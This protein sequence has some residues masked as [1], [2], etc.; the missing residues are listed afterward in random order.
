MHSVLGGGKTL[1]MMGTKTRNFAPLIHVS[2]EELVPQDH[3]YRHLERTLDLS[4]VRELVH[5]TYVGGGLPSLSLAACCLFGKNG[6]TAS[7][8]KARPVNW[9]LYRSA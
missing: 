4:F 5:E 6:H 8:S 7:S 3:L 9:L 1:I 2:L